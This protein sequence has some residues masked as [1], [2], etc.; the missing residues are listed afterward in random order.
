MISPHQRVAIW[1]NVCGENAKP[2]TTLPSKQDFS[3]VSASSPDKSGF[4][5]LAFRSFPVTE[6]PVSRDLAAR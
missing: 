5:K 3:G 1:L 2:H 4:R 6:N